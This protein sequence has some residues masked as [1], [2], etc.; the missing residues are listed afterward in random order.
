MS[1]TD[2]PVDA[3]NRAHGP[4]ALGQVIG[5]PEQQFLDD[6]WAQQP[7]LSRGVSTHSFS[8][9]F[10]VDAV[11]ELIATRGLRTPFLRMAKEGRVVP[12]SA[13][14]RGGGAGAGIAD[15]AADDKVLDL[16]ADGATLVLQG[17]HRTWGPLVG[18][19]SRL[20]HELGHPIQV[21]AYVTPAQNQ[22]FAAHY[23][24]H[25]VFVL[26]VAGRKRW[27][28][29]PPVL[30]APLSDQ[31][32]ESRRGEVADRASESPIID[33]VLAPGDALYLPRGFLHSAVAHG[34]T[35]VHLTIGVHPLTRAVLVDELL[36]EAR[37]DERMRT[38]LPAGV[39]LSD[40]AVLADHLGETVSALVALL[41]ENV[42]G[43]TACVAA[44][45]GERLSSDTRPEPVSPL[46][47][48]ALADALDADSAL[49]LRGGIRLQVDSSAAPPVLSFLDRRVVLT[50]G[51]EAA[52]TS[53][54]DGDPF[55]P[56][57]LPGLDS[58]GQLDLTRRLVL[59]GVVVE[60]PDPR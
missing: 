50:P 58:Q 49:R 22:G 26:Q 12:P 41:A 57:D 52:V 20:S 19:G 40:P 37:L 34:E 14:T 1:D 28:V 2:R 3:Q 25:D 9:L 8:D 4:S 27:R 33:E 36:R 6:V 59:G 30:P 48:A 54:L 56:V 44:R 39:D 7:L 16:F 13:F 35:S 5:V 17:L 42:E 24:T 15:Q 43:R 55:R 23:D 38:S 53:I 10:G 46:A 11:D 31:P 18:F 32:W 29:H 45:V 51:A 21:N 60:V 47:Q